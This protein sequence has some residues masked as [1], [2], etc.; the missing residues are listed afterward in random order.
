MN[1]QFA[2]AGNK[3][4]F[5]PREKTRAGELHAT[6]SVESQSNRKPANLFASRRCWRE[7]SKARKEGK[8]GKKKRRRSS[9]KI[10]NVGEIAASYVTE[11]SNVALAVSF[12]GRETITLA[13]LPSGSILHSH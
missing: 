4:G 9:K 11:P 3:L 7:S 1:I 13:S 10:S 12:C 2:R 5:P 8:E 6:E